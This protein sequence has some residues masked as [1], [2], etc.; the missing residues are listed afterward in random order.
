MVSTSCFRSRRLHETRPLIPR[1]T[2]DLSSCGDSCV[3]QAESGTTCNSDDLSCLCRISGFLNSAIKCISDTC[4]AGEVQPDEE[5]IS[6]KC[7]DALVGSAPASPTTTPSTPPGTTASTSTT[8]PISRTQSL[9]T[10][11]KA[12]SSSD[13]VNHTETSTDTSTP[14]LNPPT[15]PFS[16]SDIPASSTDPLTRLSGIPSASETSGSSFMTTSFTDLH[17]SSGSI[18]PPGSLPSASSTPSSSTSPTSIAPS[19]QVSPHGTPK[20][21]IIALSVTLVLVGLFAFIMVCC[22]C[23]KRRRRRALARYRVQEYGGMPTTRTRTTTSEGGTNSKK[24]ESEG[25]SGWETRRAS[26]SSHAPTTRSDSE[27]LHQPEL[28][29]AVLVI[30][31]A[32]G[33]SNDNRATVA[34][35]SN[36]GGSD[37]GLSLALLAYPVRQTDVRAPEL[38][39]PRDTSQGSASRGSPTRSDPRSGSEGEHEKASSRTRQQRAARAARPAM[40]EPSD[41]VPPTPESRRHVGFAAWRMGFT[42]DEHDEAP[43]PY[44]PRRSPEGSR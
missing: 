5:I 4:G 25:L 16:A 3:S 22:V 18:T 31:S 8:S 10:S 35:S 32:E 24:T 14:P 21:I 1:S 38:T 15:S 44:E 17:T 9:P 19:S 37:G 40:S 39:A 26:V 7:H 36:A 34:T 6:Q 11:S 27:P 41:V 33:D 2:F 20:P 42:E 30:S 23:R 43:P 28:A 13:S 29:D 12:T